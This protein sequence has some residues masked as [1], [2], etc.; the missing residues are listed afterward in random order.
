MVSGFFRKNSHR[1]SSW[2]VAGGLSVIVWSLGGLA[3]SNKQS[4]PAKKGSSESGQGGEQFRSAQTSAEEKAR[5][6]AEEAEAKTAKDKAAKEKA[7]EETSKKKKTTANNEND[8]EEEDADLQ[9]ALSRTGLQSRDAGLLKGF[10]CSMS[11]SE[12]ANISRM[13]SFLN[14]RNASRF[15][16]SRSTQFSQEEIEALKDL[17][18]NLGGSTTKARELQEAL[19]KTSSSKSSNANSKDNLDDED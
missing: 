2:V 16:G 19:C 10:A 3:C 15:L 17:G 9:D 18:T 7:A 6:D 13:S 4:A 1:R 5:L 8:D 12:L 11:P 14:S